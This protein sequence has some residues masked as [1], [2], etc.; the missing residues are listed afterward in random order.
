VYPSLA[1]L[2]LVVATCARAGE[3]VLVSAGL[4]RSYYHERGLIP[5]SPLATALSSTGTEW[6]STTATVT[7]AAPTTYSIDLSDVPRIL[8]RSI[9]LRNTGTATVV[10]PWI[11][12][13]AK[14]NWYSNQA[15]LDEALGSESDPELRAFRLWDLIRA[16]RYN[17]FP[18]ES[19]SELH[20]PVKYLN[21]YG[22]GF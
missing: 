9:I 15:I 5:A 2:L 7:L 16:N 18:A 6:E 1:V 22:Y 11:V 13:N 8:N 12:T 4:P 17:W 21:V 14:R 20:S 3:D 19:G 10:N